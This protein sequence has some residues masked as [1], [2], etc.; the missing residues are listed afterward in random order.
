M[1]KV[2]LD[3][4][5]EVKTTVIEYLR[6]RDLA[7]IEDMEIEFSAGL[8]V[9][10]GE[11]GA[12]KSF[13]LRAVDFLTGERIPPDLVR[14][15]A[16]A[17]VVEAQ[18]SLG[19]EEMVLRRELVS[20]NGRSKSFLNG[21]LVPGQ[22]L[23][24]L[25]PKLLIH[26]G[27]H[28]Q[29][30]FLDASFQ[31]GLPDLFL[32][33]SELPTL[34]NELL[35]KLE[36]LR[37]ERES[38][39][40][41][42]EDLAQKRS[43]LEHQ[44]KEIDKIK[45]K[46]NE[47][48]E[49]SIKRQK[50]QAAKAGRDSLNASLSVLL[51]ENGLLDQYGLFRREL[52][53]TA[54][55]FEDLK[56]DL[57][58][59]ED[60]AHRLSEITATLRGLERKVAFGGEAEEAEAIE[61]RLFALA[62]LRRK[63]NLSL[64]GI[65]NLGK[66]IEENLSA[67]DSAGLDRSALAKK[68]KEVRE[69]LQNILTELNADRTKAAEA[70]AE[71]LKFELVELGFGEG[72]DLYFDFTQVQLAPAMEDLPPLFEGRPRLVWAPNPG[73]PHKPLDKIASGGELSRFLLALTGLMAAEQGRPTLIFD[74]VDAGIGGITLE[75]VGVRLKELSGRNQTLLITH[76]PQL[77]ALADRHFQVE[78]TIQ[79]S[80]ALTTC[81]LLKGKEIREELARMAGGGKRGL[82]V[83]DQFKLV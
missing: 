70:L 9:I 41:R 54:E 42:I 29:Q 61:A 12:G 38:L 19:G 34:K 15:G 37:K 3:C 59:V 18:L 17:A 76:W 14:A 46:P 73:Q 16:D 81:R 75:K 52:A 47:E 71:R 32:A 53:V 40:K 57:E 62:A 10:T 7:L 24:E 78:K 13:I 23:K 20:S 50:I 35:R 4:L 67:L 8:N 33:N 74:E 69:Q 36:S 66:T 83:A 45:P 43:F 77:A 51:N 80:L 1:A 21:N 65:I 56:E 60:F 22:T 31:A 49:L 63:F 72:F 2:D 79:D 39:E 5:D 48:E 27:Q 44:K 55:H 6:I 26:A 11:T 58:A 28:S 68:E 64:E 30:R 82:L 25:R